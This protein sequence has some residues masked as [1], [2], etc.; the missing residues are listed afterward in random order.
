MKSRILNYRNAAL[1]MVLFLAAC[2]DPQSHDAASP[3]ANPVV[4]SATFAAPVVAAPDVSVKTRE[5]PA[6]A[7]LVAE[8]PNDETANS[9]PDKPAFIWPADNPV[10]DPN[11]YFELQ[12]TV[13][14]TSPVYM[15]GPNGG[16]GDT[17]DAVRLA[18]LDP[19]AVDETP[20]S[21]HHQLTL[22]NQ[23]IDYTARAGHLIAYAPADPANPTAARDAEGSIFYASYTRDDIPADKRPVT[24]VFN[25]GPGEPSLYLH[26]GSWG[27]KYLQVNSP[28]M[29]DGLNVPDSFPLV[30]NPQTLLDQTDLVFIDIVGSG[31]SQAI[32][33][34]SSQDFW[35][36]NADAQIFRDFITAYINRYNRQ[37]SPKYLY[38]ESF[39]GIRTPIVADLLIKAGTKQYAPDPSGKP[40]IVLSGLVLQSPALDYA[41]IQQG[42]FPT[43]GMTADYYGKGTA[44]G[45]MSEAAYAD[46]LRSYTTSRQIPI[47]DGSM[48]ASDETNLALSSITGYPLSL[49]NTYGS[50]AY[51]ENLFLTFF[52]ITFYPNEYHKFNIYDLRMNTGKKLTY[53]LD[54]YEDAGFYGAI[55]PY[56]LEE[57]GYQNKDATQLYGALIA[58]SYWKLNHSA[59]KPDTS[60]P[61]LVEALAL[62]PELRVVVMHGYHDSMTPFYQSEVELLQGGALPQFADRLSVKGYNGGHRIYMTSTSRV[63]M[64]ADL[65]DFIKSPKTVASSAKTSVAAR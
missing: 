30:D 59:D 15:A 29:P 42:S 23:T 22:N 40:A 4:S 41:G 6:T 17:P 50:Y 51:Y 43:A 10:V 28:K 33:P 27:P 53:D 52:G 60:V 21:K 38:G 63:A 56:L 31:L 13:G 25:G 11:R 3:G 35:A 2:D 26:L 44:R 16:T 39:G 65:R 47:R 7:V 36:T 57:F 5:A 54:H 32:K 19:L 55:K 18:S 45:T 48:A 1:S 34:H 8:P 24:F 61:D 9:V 12:S 62:A 58:A 37:S 14:A 46:Y 64:S 49:I 20:S